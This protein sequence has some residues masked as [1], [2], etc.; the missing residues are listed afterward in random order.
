MPEISRLS[1]NQIT[2]GPQWS[3]REAVEGY[4]RHGV[5]GI[6]VWRD[7]LR[8]FGSADAAASLLRDHGMQVSGL[9]V[10]GL[11][12]A[13]DPAG[14]RA[15]LDDNRAA[16]EEAATIGARA[17]V[18]VAGGLADGANDLGRARDRVLEGLSILLPEARA[19]GVTIGLEPLHPMLTSARSVLSTLKQANDWCDMLGD[20]PELGVVIDV[21]HLWWDPELEKEISRAGKR[22]VAFH[23]SDWL[24]DTCDLRLDRGMMGDGV[25]DIRRIRSRVE[26]AGFTGHCEVEIFSARNWWKRPGDEVV[27]V[28]CER[29]RS[30]V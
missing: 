25:I 20:G 19:A 11:L 12:T 28:I 17:V 22:I 13:D 27:R 29:Y 26:A 9:C 30:A 21:Y 23:V 14:F 6:A 18:F 3:L 5:H 15:S 16:I 24:R 8:D 2:T 7:K 1:I 10:G 4:A